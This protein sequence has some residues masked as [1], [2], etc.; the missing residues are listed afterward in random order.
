MRAFLFPSSRGS[1]ARQVAI[2]RTLLEVNL[3]LAVEFAWA[4]SRCLILSVRNYRAILGH[5]DGDAFRP[6]TISVVCAYGGGACPI[7]GV[8]CT[9]AEA[10]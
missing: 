9:F 6:A 3:V 1:D 7:G 10:V 5:L 8:D 4:L 2:N